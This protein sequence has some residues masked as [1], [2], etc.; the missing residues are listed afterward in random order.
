MTEPLTEARQPF[1]FTAEH[2]RRVSFRIAE[3][4]EERGWKQR[5]VSHR[6]GIKPDR[7]SRIERGAQVRVDELVGL[8][9]AFGVGLEEFL[10][11]THPPA[12]DELARLTR[13][14]RSMASAADLAAL[15]RVLSAV[16]A[17]LRPGAPE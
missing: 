7:L 5:E 4:R 11:A 14:I 3:L 15:V 16:K 12:E 6:S 1:S 2:Y 17:G 13:E 9:Q 8:C 10:F